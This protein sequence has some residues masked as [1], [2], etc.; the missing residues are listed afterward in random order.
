MPELILTGFYLRPA[1][2]E[3]QK[4]GSDQ[5]TAGQHSIKTDADR[6]GYFYPKFPSSAAGVLLV[7]SRNIVW[8]GLQAFRL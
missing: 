5:K 7:I 4:R 2:T 1:R 6:G 8:Q 3:L